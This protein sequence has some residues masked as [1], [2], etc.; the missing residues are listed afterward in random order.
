MGD[1]YL[2]LPHQPERGFI[3]EI[4]E[5]YPGVLRMSSSSG[6]LDRST[7]LDRECGGRN[8]RPTL[9]GFSAS[10]NRGASGQ[11]QGLRY[12]RGM[13][14]TNGS[15]EL[16][17]WQGRLDPVASLRHSMEQS[18]RH[19]D[20]VTMFSISEHR[21]RFDAL[22]TGIASRGL[23]SPDPHHPPGFEHPRHRFDMRAPGDRS[24]ARLTAT[25]PRAI[26]GIL[27][28]S[29]A[30]GSSEESASRAAGLR[31][32][33]QSVYAFRSRRQV[34]RKPLLSYTN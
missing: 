16:P 3:H 30:G 31:P 23:K 29:E 25:V 10:R 19:F 7:D 33:M 22:F 32:A 1:R 28:R 5:G 15:A 11:P 2:P 14:H 12:V 24:S 34:R 17:W 18:G 13:A 9:Q 8:S 21:L 20:F 6:A 27:G 4:A 26:S